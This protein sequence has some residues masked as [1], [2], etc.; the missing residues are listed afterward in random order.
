MVTGTLRV[1]VVGAGEGDG[2]TEVVVTV[3]VV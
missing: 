2:G 1:V 3:P